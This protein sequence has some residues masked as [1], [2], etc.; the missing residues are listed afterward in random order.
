MY[1]AVHIP[2]TLSGIPVLLES[3]ILNFN[4]LTRE[5]GILATH[6]LLCLR[7]SKVQGVHICQYHTQQTLWNIPFYIPT[8]ILRKKS[9]NSQLDA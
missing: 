2:N 7:Q 9:C 1:G 4:Y 3:P 8:K 6:P 5:V